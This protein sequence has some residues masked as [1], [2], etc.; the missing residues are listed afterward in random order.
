M[1]REKGL[2]WS[3]LCVRL[4]RGQWKPMPAIRP[5]NFGL[6]AISALRGWTTS[7]SCK[8]TTLPE[9][10]LESDAMIQ[11]FHY[12]E[13]GGHAHNEDAFATLSHPQNPNCQLGVIADGQGGRAGGAAAA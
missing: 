1:R 10:F 6:C 12:S 9:K 4:T 8:A 5:R 7:S 11:A 3:S 13:A 2:R